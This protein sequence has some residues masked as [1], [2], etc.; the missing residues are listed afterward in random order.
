ME[1]LQECAQS[2]IQFQGLGDHEWDA[3][4]KMA[5]LSCWR[6]PK[7]AALFVISITEFREVNC[8][9]GQPCID[10]GIHITLYHI[11]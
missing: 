11:F 9:D 1:S 2:Q 10:T 5:N 8:C 6:K 7:N 4:A 3:R